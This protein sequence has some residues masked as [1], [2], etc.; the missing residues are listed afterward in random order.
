MLKWVF[1][2][3]FILNFG[4]AADSV[5]EG[6]T[7][8]QNRHYQEAL[9]VFKQ[10]ETS[11]HEQLRPLIGQLFC[12]IALGETTQIDPTLQLISA[13]FQGFTDCDTPPKTGPLT[14]EQQ[15]MS[16]LCRRHIREIANR[17]RQ[18][19][20]KLVRESVPG[21]FEKIKV[22]RQLYPFIDSLEQTGI[23]C[24]QNNYPWD[25]CLDPLLLQLETWNS[26]GL[27]KPQ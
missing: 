27:K 2:L 14:Q 9:N 4:W 1:L 3:T 24:C 10:A 25:C 17:M 20:E 22:L 16:Y 23:G 12:H 7:L 19:V 5:E 6:V 21:I 18:T 15:H 11:D 13:H 8:Y 26:F